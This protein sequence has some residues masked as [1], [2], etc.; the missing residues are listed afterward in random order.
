MEDHKYKLPTAEEMI[1]WSA[2]AFPEGDRK[3]Q[4]AYLMQHDPFIAM[5]MEGGE[6]DPYL[7]ELPKIINPHAKN[8]SYKKHTFVWGTGIVIIV[9]LVVFSYYHFSS[10][11]ID[12]VQIEQGTN[13]Y[14][15]EG[16]FGSPETSHKNSLTSPIISPSLEKLT[17]PQPQTNETTTNDAQSYIPSIAP[18]PLPDLTSTHLKP[19]IT[20]ILLADQMVYPYTERKAKENSFIIDDTHIPAAFKNKTDQQQDQKR[21]LQVDYLEYLTTALQAFNQQNW[22]LS[23]EMMGVILSQYP[24][25][26]NALYYKAQIFYFQGKK[27]MALEYFQK[28]L[29]HPVHVF[30][31]EAKEFEEL[32]L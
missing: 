16:K 29:K 1:L 9:T 32:C 18:R 15:S 11:K 6:L 27:T 10:S 8:N 14:E 20:T 4:I 5:A 17:T 22:T 30:E 7:T 28:V 31:K 3:N 12:V 19:I 13:Q 2:G 23:S 21:K 25:D 24:D 26:I